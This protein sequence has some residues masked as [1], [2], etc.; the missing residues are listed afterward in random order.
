MDDESLDIALWK[1]SVLGPLVSARLE[2]GDRLAW[3]LEIAE[4]T[5][6][7]PD[8]KLVTLSAR[9]LEAW[10]YAY[11][12]GGLAALAPQP[13]ADRGTTRAIEPPVAD[14]I[15]RAKREK[16]RRSIRRIIRML[17][18]AGV[19]RRRELSRSSVHR[20]LAAHGLSA[21]P[22]RGPSAERRSFLPEHA[23]D[24]WIGDSMHGPV[25]IAPDGKLRKAYLLTQLD[26]ATRY[27]PHSYFALGES[28]PEHE[29]GFKQALLKGGRPLT[30]YVD[31]GAAYIARSL[32]IICAETA[33]HLVHTA[34]KD[35]EAK[36]A[37]ER[38][39]RTWREEVGDE[40]PDQPLPLAELN[41]IHWAW[42]NAEY[43]ARVHETTS[44]APK[45]HWLSELHHLRPLPRGIDL[46]A[47]FLHRDNRTVRKDATVRWRGRWLE[48][49]PELQG[50]RV[51]LRY[52]PTNTAALPRV[53]FN[54]RF[55][56]DTVALD[57]HRNAS[58]R[59]R[60]NLGQPDPDVTPTGLDP[61]ALIEREHY[62]RTRRPGPDN[63]ED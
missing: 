35:C 33:T 9:T 26:A 29:H 17:E 55:V 31:L 32:R 7:R 58:R 45:E 5:H 44:R 59:R 23:G 51:E 24:L 46:D 19:V 54:G 60:R 61:L 16:P 1:L 3:L 30:Y 12:R 13:R 21:R 14:V 57:R 11:R 39:H 34:P 18:R 10:L 22:K 36:G 2:H 4:R 53:F 15:L 52:D 47:L 28:A 25:A 40:L 63:Q 56:C 20:L 27:A 48:V 62:Q 6:Q 49:R 41:A 37:I 8:G 38:W 50:Q 42:L 43:H